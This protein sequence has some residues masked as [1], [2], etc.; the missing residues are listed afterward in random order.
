MNLPEVNI[1]DHDIMLSM[2]EL[3]DPISNSSDSSSDM[4]DTSSHS[5]DSNPSALSFEIPSLN[6][7]D[8]E[9]PQLDIGS[10]PNLKV[11]DGPK[12]YPGARITS[13]Q[14]MYTLVSWFSSYPGISKS[15]FSRLLHILHSFILP[16]EN[17]LPQSYDDVL[18]MMQPFLSSIKDYHCCVNDCIIFRDSDASDEKYAKLSECPKCGEDRY[19]LGTNIPR[20]RFKYFPLENRVRQ[21]FS[22]PTT[23]Q[24]LQQHVS[25]VSSTPTP[26]V[27][28]DIHQSP[29]WK[30][31]YSPTGIFAG[32]SRSLSLAIC[33]DGLNPFSREKNS[34][35]VCPMFLMN[36]NLP[37][38]VRKLAG[39]IMLTGLIPG[40]REPK[41]I[42]PYVDVLVDDIMHLNTLTVHDGYRNEMF[43]LKVEI[44]LNIFDYPGQNKVLKCQGMLIYTLIILDAFQS[45]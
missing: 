19:E 21:L 29:V 11:D 2:C 1:P 20:K 7:D 37:S 33:L 45:I 27:I 25:S 5:S 42:D 40:P 14:A 32:D 6:I 23:S 41:H 39:S 10:S 26:N 43:S 17:S 44:V 34:Y 22:N 35:S 9:I 36:L 12:L 13:E 38:H 28:T 15:A 30:S 24:L 31:W 8:L 18:K 16:A 3:K 4:S